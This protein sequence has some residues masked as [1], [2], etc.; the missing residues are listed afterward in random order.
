MRRSAAT[1]APATSKA[2][3]IGLGA[4]GK[5]LAG[6]VALAPELASLSVFQPR[7]Q[8]G[9]ELAAAHA[10][11]VTAAADVAE[12]VRGAEV[13]FTCLPRSSD[14][15]SV[16]DAAIAGR[17]LAPGSVWIDCTSGDPTFAA[18]IAAMLDEEAG[19]T[20]VDAAVEHSETVGRFK[21]HSRLVE[22]LRRC[23]RRHRLQP[24]A[25]VRGGGERRAREA[26]DMMRPGRDVF[27]GVLSVRHAKVDVGS[28]VHNDVKTVVS[29]RKGITNL[30]RYRA[31]HAVRLRDVGEVC[32][33]VVAEQ[34]ILT[35]KRRHKQI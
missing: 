7:P 31:F 34:A 21:T 20:Y 26:L 14:V 23:Q 24:A 4:I 22:A 30:A 5:V 25:D 18:A 10:G 17:A 9:R 6:R 11:K 16:A 29:P 32:T 33:T 12:A 27:L 8:V 13:V 19:C 1:L 15:K 28:H 3:F 35:A 2:A